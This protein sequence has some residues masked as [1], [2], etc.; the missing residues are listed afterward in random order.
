MFRRRERI[1][2]QQRKRLIKK[3]KGGESCFWSWN[4]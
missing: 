3:D 4:F 2:L 1:S